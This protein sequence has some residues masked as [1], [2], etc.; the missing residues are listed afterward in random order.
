M[1][2][3]Q[4]QINSDQLSLSLRE[5]ILKASQF[6]KLILDFGEKSESIEIYLCHSAHLSPEFSLS[7]KIAEKLNNYSLL[8]DEEN[9]IGN[10]FYLV[11]KSNK[12]ESFELRIDPG[13]PLKVMMDAAMSQLAA[14]EVIT[15]AGISFFANGDKLD[16][17]ESADDMCLVPGMVVDVMIH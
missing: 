7:D 11:V 13:A 9:D 1:E 3:G 5:S 4:F 2:N 8:S 10:D 14:N 16:P 15:A 6:L 17:S 12:G